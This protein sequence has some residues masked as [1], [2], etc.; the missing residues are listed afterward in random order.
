MN[1]IGTALRDPINSRL[2]R[3]YVADLTKEKDAVAE[4]EGD[5]VS[6]HQIQPQYAIRYAR[7]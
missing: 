5:H 2:A 1:A 6:K 3:W 7:P 4:L